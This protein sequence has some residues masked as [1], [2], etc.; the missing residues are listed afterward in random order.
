MERELEPVAPSP[1]P[2]VAAPASAQGPSLVGALTPARV[3]A[4]QRTAGNQA[5]TALLMRD[6]AAAPTPAA[7]PG[8]FGTS[9][10]APTSSGTA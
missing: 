5:V 3:L 10:G 1:A 4:L 6:E 2:S 7:G 9:G 8:D